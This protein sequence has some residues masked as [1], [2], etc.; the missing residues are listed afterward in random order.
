[1]ACTL[2]NDKLTGDKERPRYGSKLKETKYTGWLNAECDHTLD[3]GPG[4][5]L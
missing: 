5:N 2:P 1:M 4:K 3:P